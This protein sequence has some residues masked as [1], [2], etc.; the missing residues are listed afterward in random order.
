MAVEGLRCLKLPPRSP[1]PNPFAERSVRSVKYECLSKLILFGECSLQR[2]LT[3]FVG[4]YHSERHHQG[5]PTDDYPVW[6][7]YRIL[8]LR[9]RYYPSRAAKNRTRIKRI[10]YSDHTGFHKQESTLLGLAAYWKR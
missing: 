7:E 5:K 10:Q 2:A 9:G 3:E 4:H 6:S 1:D 8:V